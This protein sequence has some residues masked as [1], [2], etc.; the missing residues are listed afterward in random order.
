MAW[1]PRC[2]PA[3]LSVLRVLEHGGKRELILRSALY[4]GER[5]ALLLAEALGDMYAIR[6]DV[7]GDSKLKRI[8]RRRRRRRWRRARPR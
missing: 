3:T 4:R 6:A 1:A 5:A 7:R 8:R 2:G